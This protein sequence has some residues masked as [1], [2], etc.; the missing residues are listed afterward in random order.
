MVSSAAQTSFLRVEIYKR[1]ALG[2]ETVLFSST[3]P[4]INSLTMAEILFESTQPIHL[5]DLTD[6]LGARV[7]VSTTRSSN[8]TVS[9]VIG[10]GDAAYLTTPLP[11]RHSQTR[12]RSEPNSHPIEAITGLAEALAAVGGG[13]APV[14]AYRTS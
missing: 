7:Y 4:E 10:D 14:E 12:G 1:S 9:Y 5:L 8:T 3:S 6:R 2:V 13:P 11:L